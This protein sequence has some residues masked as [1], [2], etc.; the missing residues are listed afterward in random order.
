M[1]NEPEDVRPEVESYPPEPHDEHADPDDVLWSGGAHKKRVRRKRKPMAGETIGHLNLTP[2]MD[3]MTMLLVFLV[4]SFATE[5]ANINVSLEMRPPESS[6]KKV[7]EAATKVTI[8]KVAIFVE[9]SEVVRLDKVDLSKQV[10]IPEVTNA[11]VERREHLKALASRG[12]G[13]EFDGRLLV[14]ADAETPY[15]LV[16]AVLV[17]AGEAQFAEYKLVLMQKAGADGGSH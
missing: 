7:M 16:T 6:T 17:T 13:D 15:K 3:I 10:S 14:V 8:S 12:L 5:P 2:M 9:D 11:L 4:M 1:A